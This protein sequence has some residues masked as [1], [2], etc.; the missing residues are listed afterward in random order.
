[1]SSYA[2]KSLFW[3]IIST[4]IICN[5]LGRPNILVLLT[6]DQDVLLGSLDHMPQ[7]NALIRQE[8]TTLE[9]GFVHT[10][11]CCP[12]RSSILT[13]RYIH[14]GGARDNTRKGNCYGEEWKITEQTASLGVWA[15]EAGYK[16]GYSGKYLNNYGFDKDSEIEVPPG[17]NEWFGLVG[18]SV[19]YNYSLVESRDNGQPQTKSESE[20]KSRAR[21]YTVYTH[22]EDYST[23]YL[24]NVLTRHSLNVMEEFLSSKDPFLMVHAWPTPHQPFTPAPWAT[25]KFSDLTAPRTPNF[26]A[27][28]ASQSQKHW[29]M[30]QM[31]PINSTDLDLINDFYH[32][33][34]ESLL[35]VDDHVR[36]FVELLD[37]HDQL[38]NTYILYTSDNGFQMGQ[39][40]LAYDKRH[41][42]EHDLRVPFL[43]RGPAIPPNHTLKGHDC[44]A[45]N[46]DIA[47]TILD[48]IQHP[49]P[50]ILDG[51]S[52]LQCFKSTQSQRI[53]FL[54]S[55]FG[56]FQ[57]PC[58]LWWCPPG[59]KNGFSFPIDSRNNT[60]DCIRTWSKSENSIFCVF[61]LEQN[62]VEYYDLT[63]D[64]WQL[65]NTQS[66]LS[67]STRDHYMQRMK[68][69]KSCKG[70]S[71]HE[72]P[73][74]RPDS[75]IRHVDK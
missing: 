38:D 49:N 50:P 10:P 58:E 24:P 59:P 6:D 21:S 56:E 5:I 7:L 75:W 55:Y 45:L 67:P 17:W 66:A 72:L 41:L 27:S 9:G 18:N 57:Q 51:T 62:F 69:L 44:L 11:I 70:L 13:G 64:P 8:G 60:Y 32:S 28:W 16:T 71:C 29:I 26:N 37:R 46:I 19:Y 23:D 63:I 2:I 61:E 34:V 42:Y 53:D 40:R 39:H 52:L 54:V 22:G 73:P 35:S 74:T 4:S 65:N 47:P 68:Y 3:L 14:N 12:S 43:L 48:M 1:M 20:S 31:Q 33:R 15:Q 30:R 25:N 36:Q